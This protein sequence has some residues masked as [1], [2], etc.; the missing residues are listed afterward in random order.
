MASLH[1][2][3]MS[4]SLSSGLVGLSRYR[5]FVRPSMAAQSSS[6]SVVGTKATSTPSRGISFLRS[7]YVPPYRSCIA[8]TLSPFPTKARR[9]VEIAAMPDENAND[10]S[11]P[12]S[13]AS[14]SSTASTVGLLFLG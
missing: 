12:S 14:F 3:L 7:P 2:S 5:T 10:A 8:T 13:E 1:V 6:G 11:A 4:I 9:A